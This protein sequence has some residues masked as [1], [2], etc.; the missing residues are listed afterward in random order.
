M[1]AVAPDVVEE[2]QP[3]LHDRTAEREIRIPVLDQRRNVGEAVAA[4]RVVEIVALR[5]LAR[6]AQKSGAAERV[7]TRLGDQVERRAAAVGFAEPARDRDLDFRRF[8]DRIA[9][10]GHAAAVERRPD[11]HAVDLNRAFVAAAAARREE[12]GRDGGAHVQA[13]RLDARHGRQHVAVAARDRNR[14]DR[15]R[16]GCVIWRLVLVWMSTTGVSPVTVT[17]SA[18]V[19]TRMSALIVVTPAPVT[20]DALALDGREA[21]QRERDGVSAR[22][23]FGNPVLAGPIGDGASHLLNQRRTAGFDRHAGQHGAGRVLDD[24]R[25]RRLSV[26]RPRHER[27]ARHHERQLSQHRHKC[28][29]SKRFGQNTTHAAEDSKEATKIPSTNYRAQNKKSRRHLRV[30]PAFWSRREVD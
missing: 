9:E 21:G 6:R 24:A 26:G 23:Q 5:P 15:P 11:I 1:V 2:P 20:F 29:P 3:V 25:E 10:A 12:I 28:L 7:A 19:P 4:Q 13:G 17:V 8:A 16:S 27:K 14:L 30:P 22:R 18:M